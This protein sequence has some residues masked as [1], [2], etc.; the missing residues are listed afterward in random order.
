MRFRG[1]VGRVFD[2]LQTQT[3]HAVS[4]QP[5]NCFEK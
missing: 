1:R 3:E 4:T 5:Q 2:M